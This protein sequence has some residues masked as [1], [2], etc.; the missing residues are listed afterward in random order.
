[1]NQHTLDP[2]LDGTVVV[3]IG[4]DVGALVVHTSAGW[5]GEEIEISPAG[6]GHRTHV[7]VRERR[8]G[9]GTGWAAVY[10]ALRAGRYLLHDPRHG[11]TRAVHIDGGT[12]TEL[13]WD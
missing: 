13:R 9:A 1:M 10:P 8:L 5:L 6:G 2:S 3:D 4:G 12:V 7:A 11:R